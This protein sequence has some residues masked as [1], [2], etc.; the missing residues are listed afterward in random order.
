MKFG[1]ERGRKGVL[2]LASPQS[3]KSD[4]TGGVTSAHG[5]KNLAN[6]DTGNGAVRLSPSTTHTGLQT[7]GTSARQHLVDT[8]NVEGV[9]TAHLSASPSKRTKK[10]PRYVPDPQMETILSGKLDEVLVGANTGGLESLR[11]KL[12]VLVRHQVDAERE[13]VDTGTLASKIEDLDLRVGDTT[14]EPRL[15]VRLVYSQNPSASRFL[16]PL[17]VELPQSKSRD[18]ARLFCCSR[19]DRKTYSCSSGSN[20]RDGGPFLLISGGCSGGR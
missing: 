14:V 20:G 9:G 1:G 12:L 4:G 2:V 19:I 18:P 13:V 15:G 10:A 6:V 8:D 17:S 16:L 3:L 5:Q 7:I 11:G